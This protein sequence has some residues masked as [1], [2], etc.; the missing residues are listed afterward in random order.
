MNP[1]FFVQFE[2]GEVQVIEP[3]PD[4]PLFIGRDSKSDIVVAEKKVSRQHARILWN[5]AENTISLEDLQS[6]NGTRLNGAKI[7]NIA[8]LKPGD[9]IQVGSANIQLEWIEAAGAPKSVISRVSSLNRTTDLSNP[10]EAEIVYDYFSADEDSELRKT[11][12]RMISG[13]VEDLAL[14][15]LLQMLA[16]TRKSGELIVSP[17]AILQKRNPEEGCIFMRDGQVLHVD[18]AGKKNEKAF[19]ELLKLRKGHFALYPLKQEDFSDFVELPLEALLLEGLRVLDEEKAAQNLLTSDSL[20]PNPDEPL[21]G[22]KPEELR[23]FQL[24]WKLKEVSS[25]LDQSP[26]DK[27]ET[28]AILLKLIRNNFLR[29]S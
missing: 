28:E 10:Q 9:K 12:G 23:L 2:D 27:K 11:D 20:E 5:A 1:K 6:L 13:K 8:F 15:D 18:Y 3:Q 19:F 17:K 4:L 7:T 25:I 14:P 16:T 21:T 26:L 24:A 22:L 29:K